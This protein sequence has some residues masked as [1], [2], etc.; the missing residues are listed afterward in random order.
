M[1]LA[2]GD[3]EADDVGVDVGWLMSVNVDVELDVCSAMRSN[4]MFVHQ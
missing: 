2:D 1:M 3:D 4:D